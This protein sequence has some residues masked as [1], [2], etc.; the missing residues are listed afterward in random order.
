MSCGGLHCAGCA[1]GASIPVMPLL[2]VYGLAWIA[3][4][5]IEVAAISAACGVLAVAAVVA[6]MRWQDRRAARVWAQRPAQLRA[7][8][9]AEVPRPE[10]PAIAPVVNLNFYGLP[11]DERATIIRTAIERTGP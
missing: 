4:H 5:I 3:E 8:R 1:G 9:V 11:D 2:A 7:E 10:R 6:L